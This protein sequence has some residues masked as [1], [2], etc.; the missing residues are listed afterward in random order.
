MFD[1]SELLNRASNYF[2]GSGLENVVDAKFADR[3]SE[4]GFGKHDLDPTQLADIQAL[5]EG[6]GVD[7]SGMTESQ[8]GEL[9][10]SAKEN[11]GLERPDLSQFS[12]RFPN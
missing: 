2:N 12:S 10:A 5:L 11:S 3:L 7:L 4:L 1:L 9:L 6:A 8:I